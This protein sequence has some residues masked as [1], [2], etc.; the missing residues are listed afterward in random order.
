MMTVA[1]IA[2]MAFD[3]V[4]AQLSG[5]VHSASVNGSAAGRVV[6]DT[7]RGPSVFPGDSLKDKSK[8]VWCEG[9]DPSAGDTLAY[10][11]V[12][13][14]VF[15]S[16]DVLLSGGL[17][18]AVVLP[19]GEFE[20]VTVEFQRKTRVSNGS[21]GFSETWAAI[22]GTPTTA[23]MVAQRGAEVVEGD[24]VVAHEGWRL[25]LPYFSGLTAADCVEVSGRRHNIRFC[26][27]WERR[28]LWLLV[29]V[30]LG[31]AV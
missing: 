22:S 3:S 20:A 21:G 10:S 18:K 6:E 28:R 31:V 30:D 7:P 2:S 9:F 23:F 15:W 16:Q 11:G 26:N 8:V 5:V 29:D 27:D 24:R 14:L 12:D 17:S 1:E 25:L 4:S 13:H 19:S